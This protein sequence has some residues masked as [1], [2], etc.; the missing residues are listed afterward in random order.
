MVILNIDVLVPGHE[1]G[2]VLGNV[3]ANNQKPEEAGSSG[4]ANSG[5]RAAPVAQQPAAARP[6]ARN[7]K[8][9]TLIQ[10]FIL[11]N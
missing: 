2:R 1:V 6:A 10:K 9:F 4:M 8:S 3:N 11:I 5:A 7:G